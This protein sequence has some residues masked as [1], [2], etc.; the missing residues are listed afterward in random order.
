M[1]LCSPWALHEG[2]C[3]VCGRRLAAVAW[4]SILRGAFKRWASAEA[5][6]QCSGMTAAATLLCCWSRHLLSMLP[7]TPGPIRHL[8]R[9]WYL[10]SDST[11]SPEPSESRVPLPE[12]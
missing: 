9:P 12:S 7:W 1:S 10:Q 5:P 2:T 8:P 3:A 11:S 6:V 4:A